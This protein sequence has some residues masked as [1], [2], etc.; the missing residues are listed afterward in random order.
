MTMHL[1]GPWLTTT[2]TKQLEFKMTKAKRSELE[3]RWRDRNNNL[4][5][6]GLKKESFEEFLS[7]VFGRATKTKEP[8]KPLAALLQ[9]KKPYVDPNRDTSKYLSLNGG[10]DTASAT[11]TAPKV[12]TGTKVKG[13]GTMHKS[14]AVPIFS[15]ED[16][17]AIA[18]MRR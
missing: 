11:K 16:A 7:F 18:T 6:M 17:V 14:N 4:K 12:Y 3:Q 2:S 8:V 15:D 5:S 13:I 10:I 1:E 9:P